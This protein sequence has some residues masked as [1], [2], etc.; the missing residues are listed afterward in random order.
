VGKKDGAKRHTFR[1]AF[2]AC[3]RVAR[4]PIG[5]IRPRE[6]LPAAASKRGAA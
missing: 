2:A 3:F 5:T 6:A 1:G 4:A